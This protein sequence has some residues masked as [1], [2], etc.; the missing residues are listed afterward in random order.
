MNENRWR[1]NVT[2]GCNGKYSLNRFENDHILTNDE[3]PYKYELWKMVVDGTK[4]I[5][6][7]LNYKNISVKRYTIALY[8]FFLEVI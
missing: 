2:K 8:Y 7:R 6:N 5:P 3:C 1:C 4:E